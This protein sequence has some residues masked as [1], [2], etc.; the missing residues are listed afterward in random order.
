MYRDVLDLDRDGD[1]AE[2]TP[3]DL[4]GWSRFVNVV[5]MGSYER[6]GIQ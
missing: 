3:Y 5:D 1:R 6:I 2:K 4:N